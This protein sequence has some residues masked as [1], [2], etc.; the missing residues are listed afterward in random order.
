M[1]AAISE[2]YEFPD[3]DE[4]TRTTAFYTTETT[5]SE[6]GGSREHIVEALEVAIAVNV[7]AAL[8]YSVRVTDAYA[9]KVA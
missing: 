8:V 6:T 5:G 3:F 9:A 4:N 1:L 7:G 2:N